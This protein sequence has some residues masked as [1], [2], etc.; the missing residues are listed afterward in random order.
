M[1]T[2]DILRELLVDDVIVPIEN[3]RCI[4]SEAGSDYTF[5][6]NHLPKD[7]IIIKCDRF[8]NLGEK[9]FKGKNQECKRAD[10]ALIS[11]SKKVIMLFELKR[12]SKS[13]ILK[14][15]IA[16]LK[17]AKCVVAYCGLIVDSFFGKPKIFDG[18]VEKYYII[19]YSPSEKREFAA[20]E[21]MDNTSPEKAKIIHGKFRSFEGL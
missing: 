11:E 7:S 13:S 19:R 16:Q 1:N 6:L 12:S 20:S 18:F 15:N 4:M 10:Y 8:P 9:F 2:T 17:G 5:S 21:T 14:D 3:N